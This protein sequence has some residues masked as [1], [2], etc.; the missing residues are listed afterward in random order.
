M[1]LVKSLHVTAVLYLVFVGLA[2]MGLR[3]WTAA[4][5]E[6]VLHNAAGRHG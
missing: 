1:Y 3:A 4:R 6:A 2:V 5:N